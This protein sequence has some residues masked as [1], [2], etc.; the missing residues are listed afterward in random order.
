M[1]SIAL[2]VTLCPWALSQNYE[3][4]TDCLECHDEVYQKGL[5]SFYIHSP[6]E[7]KQCGRCHLK[8]DT[9]SKISD[10]ISKEIAQPVVFIHPEYRAEHTILLKGLVARAV[11][12]INVS[13]EDMS[14]N[15]V[16]ERFTS[17]VPENIRNVRR[18]D[19]KAPNISEVKVDPVVKGIFLQTTI[20]WQTDEP[21]S[22]WVEYGSSDQYG[23]R[24]AEDNALVKDHGVNIYELE[25]E[26]HYHFRVGSQDMFGNESVS[27]NRVFNT[28]KISPL[29]ETKERGADTRDDR[30]LAVNRAEV[31]L[32]NSELGLYLETTKPA[33]VTV[34]YVKVEER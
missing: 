10:S 18:D 25:V 14:G 23:K 9:V 22:S 5:S 6:F 13:F 33:S 31:F 30:T 34:E 8:P 4:G 1:V 20:T 28:G 29:S 12:D 11:Y 27:G 21:S 16:E 15:N 2:I 7:K 3:A 24:T 26:K 19:K 17:V 32:L